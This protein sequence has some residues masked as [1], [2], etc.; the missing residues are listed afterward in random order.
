MLDIILLVI[1]V[2]FGGFLVSIVQFGLDQ[3]HD[4]STTEIKSFITWYVW[5]INF[6]GIL[7]KLIFACI[8][9]MH[10]IF[11][12]DLLPNE[13]FFAKRYYSTNN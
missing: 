7:M 13:H 10:S 5:T 11:R 4:A 8:T 6:A 3:L 1:S 12:Q 9:E 2:G